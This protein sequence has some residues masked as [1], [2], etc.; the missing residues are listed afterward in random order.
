VLY[1]SV[2]NFAERLME[3]LRND[4]IDPESGPDPGG[5]QIRLPDPPLALMLN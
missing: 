3:S 1:G 4:T 2:R 5:I